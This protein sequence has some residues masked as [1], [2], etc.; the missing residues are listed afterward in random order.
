MFRFTD[1]EIAKQRTQEFYAEAER[2]RRIKDRKQTE[3]VV[4]IRWLV[5]LWSSITSRIS[6]WSCLLQ[7]R[8]PQSLSLLVRNLALAPNPCTCA[9]EPCTE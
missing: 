3:R 2:N 4:H 1:L 6:R 9:P 7:D 5:W 8:L